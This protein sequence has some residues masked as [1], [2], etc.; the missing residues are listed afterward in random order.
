[1]KVIGITG[2]IGSGKS[3]VSKIFQALG[4]PVYS[5]DDA[6]KELMNNDTELKLEI[7]QLLG[8]D[9]YAVD[10]KLNRAWIAKQVFNNPELL[11]KLNAI[12]HPRTKAHFEKWKKQQ[13]PTIPFVLKE[14]AIL[15][16]ANANVGMDAVI[17]VFA[18]K[19]L[20]IQRIYARDGTSRKEVIARMKQQM[21]ENEKRK[22][23]D[24]VITNN[25]KHMLI[26]QVLKIFS[27]IQQLPERKS[28]DY[29]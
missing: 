13:D 12:V 10:G 17:Y 11:A 7:I 20:R 23:S 16:E 15:F 22:L 6:A 2:G 26:P 18:P 21:S 14:A 24:F 29:E 25:G 4:I 28:Y 19:I 9:A 3:T 1:M 5:A 8:Q 27:Q